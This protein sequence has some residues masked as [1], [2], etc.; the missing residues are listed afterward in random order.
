MAAA[1]DVV[2]ICRDLIRIDTTN[3][4]ELETSKGER[5][6]AEYVAEKLAEVGFEPTVIETAPGRTN[7]IVRYEGSDPS[8]GAL[9]VHGHLDVVPADASEWSVD[10]FGGEIKDG[11]LWG[12]G[13]LDD[14]SLGI[15]ELAALVDLKRRR[16][17]IARLRLHHQ[18]ASGG[19]VAI[20]GIW[21]D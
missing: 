13:A 14:K 20:S 18:P 17:P 10:P 9:L 1:D 3:T 8:R 12:R 11:Y 2:D 6:A 19:S 21:T 4:G 15:V 16:V 5:V 7:V